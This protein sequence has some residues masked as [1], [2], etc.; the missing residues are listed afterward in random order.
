MYHVCPVYNTNLETNL[1]DTFS[2]N[3]CRGRCQKKK[4]FI[5]TIKIHTKEMFSSFFF[6][7]GFMCISYKHTNWFT[8][9]LLCSR[10]TFVSTTTNER[11]KRFNYFYFLPVCVLFSVF[12]F[13][14]WL[15]IL[16]KKICIWWTTVVFLGPINVI[17][18]IFYVINKNWRRCLLHDLYVLV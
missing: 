12:F 1:S 14:G 5:Y 15:C 9:F 13:V 18:C 8:L 6:L 7:S 4:N 10:R 3:F 16:R 2:L 11:I 17:Y